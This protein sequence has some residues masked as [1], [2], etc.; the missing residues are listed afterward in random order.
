MP[1]EVIIHPIFPQPIYCSTL[2]RTLTEDELK[3]I[4]KF[5][6]TNYDGDVTQQS[7]D[8]KRIKKPKRRSK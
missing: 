1:K 3:V 5:K 7:S 2:G 6:P 8:K 4:D